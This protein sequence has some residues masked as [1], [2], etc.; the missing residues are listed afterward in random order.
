M[1]G[2]REAIIEPG[3][4]LPAD[5]EKRLLRL[6]E[7]KLVHIRPKA[8]PA[9]LPLWLQIPQRRIRHATAVYR[10]LSAGLPAPFQALK[11]SV[12]GTA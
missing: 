12:V 2:A 4:G 3:F 11:P 10:A 5:N 7:W 6:Q 8:L 1:I 9:G